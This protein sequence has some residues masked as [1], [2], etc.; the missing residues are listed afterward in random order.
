[1]SKVF[2]IVCDKR[3]VY[4]PG[5]YDL[6]DAKNIA[7][8]HAERN[9]GKTVTVMEVREAYLFAGNPHAPTLHE[10]VLNDRVTELER[11]VRELNQRSKG[12]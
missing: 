8:S 10:V 4:E 6:D 7:R 2:Y 11:Q 12:R 9:P 5:H 1:M 3:L